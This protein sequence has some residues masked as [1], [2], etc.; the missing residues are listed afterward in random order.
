MAS[1]IELH[2]RR[3]TRYKEV[4]KEREKERERQTDREVKRKI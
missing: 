1:S 4:R 3:N 2:A